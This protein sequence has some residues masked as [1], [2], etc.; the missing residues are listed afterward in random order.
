MAVFGV[1]LW[2]AVCNENMLSGSLQ[3]SAVPL[4]AAFAER[5]DFVKAQRIS[6]I[7]GEKNT[8]STVRQNRSDRKGNYRLSY[9]TMC[10]NFRTTY[11]TLD[12]LKL[13]IS[14]PATLWNTDFLNLQRANG[15]ATYQPIG[16]WYASCG[17]KREVFVTLFNCFHEF[18]V[19]KSWHVIY[20]LDLAKN[21]LL[22]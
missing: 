17:G 9:P 20:L 4:L 11:Y 3:L 1:Y 15:S 22:L 16:A 19:F 2:E 14:F 18:K 5:K 7:R 10:V 6:Q 8:I 13:C 12:F 21:S